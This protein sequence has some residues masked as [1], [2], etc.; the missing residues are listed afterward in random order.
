MSIR[1]E[2]RGK[3]KI[4]MLIMTGATIAFIFAFVSFVPEI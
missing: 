4:S 2:C 3:D 1:L